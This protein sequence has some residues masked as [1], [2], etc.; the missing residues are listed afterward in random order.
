[1]W[2][3]YFPA[4]DGIVFLIDAH[5]RERFVEAW[6]L[7]MDRDHDNTHI[8]DAIK[9]IEKGE[10]LFYDYKFDFEEGSRKTPCHCGAVNCRGWMN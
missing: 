8:N 4:V 9:D 5:D 1:M 3:D 10:E 2:K 6:D 7:W